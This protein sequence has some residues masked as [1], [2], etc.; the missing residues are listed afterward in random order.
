MQVRTL[1][2]PFL[3]LVLLACAIALGIA[4][5]TISRSADGATVTR[6]QALCTGILIPVFQAVLTA[7]VAGGAAKAALI[8]LN[9]KRSD[10]KDS[11][12]FFPW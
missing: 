4:T 7:L 10:Q 6:L 11:I 1:L 12:T 3:A 5:Y 8:A 9:N 2:P